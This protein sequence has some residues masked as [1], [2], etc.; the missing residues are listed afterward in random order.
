M[1]ATICAPSRPPVQVIVP[2]GWSSGR[3]PKI[4]SLRAIAPG[5]SNISTG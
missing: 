4:S 5:V 3:R 1:P 2:I